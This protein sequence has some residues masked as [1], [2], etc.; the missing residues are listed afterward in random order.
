MKRHIIQLM[1]LSV[2]VQHILRCRRSIPEPVS[3]IE[4]KGLTL[5]HTITG[6]PVPA[7]IISPHTS[8][9][10]QGSKIRLRTK[11]IC[12]PIIPHTSAGRHTVNLLV[13]VERPLIFLP[14]RSDYHGIHLGL[15]QSNIA[16]KILSLIEIPKFAQKP[17]SALPI[18]KLNVKPLIMVNRIPLL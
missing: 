9:P 7:V 16:F 14:R 18:A 2:I 12:L 10:V 1:R 17:P 15:P 13:I 3:N 11:G 8:A 4:P 6:P 5:N